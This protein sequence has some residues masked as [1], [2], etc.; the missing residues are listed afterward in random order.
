MTT[1]MLIIIGTGLFFLL[2]TWWAIFDIAYKDFGSFEK[3][4]IWAFVAL[5]PFIGCIL[6]LV[7][8]YRS[9]TKKNN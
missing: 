4:L 2:L 5:I 8:G 6:Y 3:K 1:K 9:G 7:F